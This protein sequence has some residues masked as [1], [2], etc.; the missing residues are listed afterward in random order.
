MVNFKVLNNY[1]SIH[2]LER[3]HFKRY[4]NFI[5]KKTFFQFFSQPDFSKVC[6]QLTKLLEF[7][8]WSTGRVKK[9]MSKLSDFKKSKFETVIKSEILVT[10]LNS[11]RLRLLNRF[12][13]ILSLYPQRSND[14]QIKQKLKGLLADNRG[15]F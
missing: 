4:P 9:L 8:Y 13:T 3:W 12:W 1:F 5:L 14:H 6:L 11:P 10:P 7:S 15:G 2:I